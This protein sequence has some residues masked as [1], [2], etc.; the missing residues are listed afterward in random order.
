MGSGSGWSRRP[1][2][3]PAPQP[4]RATVKT[5][6]RLAWII[7]AIL[8]VLAAA[9][10]LMPFDAARLAGDPTTVT[11]PATPN[12]ALAAPSAMSVA[13]APSR[14]SPVFD[15]APEELVAAVDAVASDDARV[16]LVDSALDDPLLVTYV[17][18]SA[19]FGFPDVVSVRAVEVAPGQSSLVIYSRSVYGYSDL[20]VNAARVDRWIGGL[21]ERLAETPDR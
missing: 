12:W 18:R 4:A 8:L 7:V 2:E 15:V 20:G 9:P 10:R 6:R 11:P 5:A 3:E 16:A 21:A 1:S 19:V 17:Q 14:E 13:G